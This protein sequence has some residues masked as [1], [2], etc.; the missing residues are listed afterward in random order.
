MASHTLD[1]E[2]VR[3][4]IASG[5]SPSRRVNEEQFLKYAPGFFPS[6]RVREIL[7]SFGGLRVRGLPGSELLEFEPDMAE[8]HDK[9]C[10]ILE[11][12]IGGEFFPIARYGQGALVLDEGDRVFADTG[13]AIFL[14]GRTFEQ[15]LELCLLNRGSSLCVWGW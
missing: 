12:I 4:L 11:P 1:P 7:R 14:F 3:L 10:Q 13:G 8:P 15:C 5:W 2:V 9:W 6:N